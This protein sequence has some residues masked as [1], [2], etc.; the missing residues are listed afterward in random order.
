[1]QIVVTRPH[2]QNHSNGLIAFDFLLSSLLG[3]RLCAALSFST[4]YNK[5]DFRALSYL[6][7]SVLQA[8]GFFEG[9]VPGYIQNLHHLLDN[10]HPA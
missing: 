9:D 4:L 1:M 2:T 3:I 5:K 6:G 10:P 7:F 8:A